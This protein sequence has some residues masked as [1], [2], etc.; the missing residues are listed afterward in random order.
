MTISGQIDQVIIDHLLVWTIFWW[1]TR[2]AVFPGG[3]W[4]IE[5]YLPGSWYSALYTCDF[6]EVR[7]LGWTQAKSVIDFRYIKLN[8]SDS[9]GFDYYS[10]R[11]QCQIWKNKP[12]V[13]K[14]W[15]IHLQN[16]CEMILVE[17]RTGVRWTESQE[18]DEETSVR[19]TSF[20]F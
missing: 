17:M 3:N 8:N 2:L 13:I 19:S 5:K 14:N 11:F 4:L 18:F 20:P 12:H 1:Y 10:D 15:F 9:P 7:E 6:P 16:G